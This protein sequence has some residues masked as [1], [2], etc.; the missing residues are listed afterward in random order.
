VIQDVLKEVRFAH[1]RVC[2][3]PSLGRP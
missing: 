1:S 3:R 2:N